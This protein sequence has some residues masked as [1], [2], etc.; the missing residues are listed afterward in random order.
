MGGKTVVTDGVVAVAAVVMVK[1]GEVCVI[2][3]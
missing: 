2:L 3:L 1:V